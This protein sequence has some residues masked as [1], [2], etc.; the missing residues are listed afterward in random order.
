[1]C[2]HTCGCSLRP[3]V[4]PHTLFSKS[5][6]YSIGSAIGVNTGRHS[7]QTTSRSRLLYFLDSPPLIA[8]G[9]TPSP[10]Q[11]RLTSH[12]MAYFKHRNASDSVAGERR[13]TMKCLLPFTCKGLIGTYQRPEAPPKSPISSPVSPVSLCRINPVSMLDLS[14]R[15]HN[16]E[17]SSRSSGGAQRQW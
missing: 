17:R 1:M 10:E 12:S 7:H 8:V 4:C 16:W 15:T 11:L 3:H 9:R 13:A 6:L 14:S 5:Q 2:G